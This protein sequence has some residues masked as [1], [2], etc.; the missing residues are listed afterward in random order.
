MTNSLDSFQSGEICHDFFSSGS[1]K[2]YSQ[3][4][5]VAHGR[6]GENPALSKGLMQNPITRIPGGSRIAAGRRG[7]GAD[8]L[9][10]GG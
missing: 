7:H 8:L 1:G 4:A 2:V 5:V 10:A 9:A 6:N 3:E